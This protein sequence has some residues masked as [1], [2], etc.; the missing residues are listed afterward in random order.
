[1]N[2]AIRDKSIDQIYLGII[3]PMANENETAIVFVNDVLNICH[4]YNFKSIKMFTILDNASTDGTL[5]IMQK[6]SKFNSEV[7][8]IFAPENK[9]VVDAYKR[10]YHEALNANCDWIL[11]I[12]AGYSHQPSDITKFFETMVKGYDCVFGS[13]FCKNGSFQEGHKIRYLISKGGT[14]LTN[15]LLGTKLSDM[16]GGFELFSHNAL[17]VILD[18][19]I[20]SKGPFFQTEIRTHAHRFKIKEIPICYRSPSHNL[21]KAAIYDALH[22][23]WRLFK[24]RFFALLNN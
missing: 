20:N 19:G 8:V 12:D 21:R 7:N 4:R 3:I 13:R 15:L 24:T 5:A 14:K 16:T 11:E 23:L 1:M 18:M 2:D 22:N 9:S 10:G 17:K 6:F